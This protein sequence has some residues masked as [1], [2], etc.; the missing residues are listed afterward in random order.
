MK[1]ETC[2]PG[3]LIYTL[4]P[5]N[6]KTANE[7][8]TG[9]REFPS[10]PEGNSSFKPEAGYKTATFPFMYTMIFLLQTRG[11]PYKYSPDLFQ[12]PNIACLGESGRSRSWKNCLLIALYSY[13]VLLS[14]ILDIAGR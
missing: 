14:V 10:G 1:G 8:R 6:R 3:N 7:I 11:G 2:I 12:K 5:M 13:S 9:M 4:A